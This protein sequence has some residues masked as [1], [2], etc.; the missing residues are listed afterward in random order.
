VKL[1]RTER[2]VL[3][4]RSSTEPV[5]PGHRGRPLEIRQDAPLVPLPPCP[6]L[7]LLC[8]GPRSPLLLFFREGDFAGRSWRDATPQVTVVA[9][10]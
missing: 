3:P 1:H 10:V 2:H 5:A 4:E 7:V 9:S 8:C 6:R